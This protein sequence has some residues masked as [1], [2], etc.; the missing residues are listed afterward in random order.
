MIYVNPVTFHC[1]VHYSTRTV[2]DYIKIGTLFLNNCY[3]YFLVRAN[4]QLSF[5]I[6]FG[7]KNLEQK[8]S[9]GPGSHPKILSDKKAQRCVI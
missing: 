6:Q 4:K 9:D 8:T 2:L 3:E 7:N 5:R 1:E